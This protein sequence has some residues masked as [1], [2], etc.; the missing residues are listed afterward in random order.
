MKFG[1]LLVF[2][3]LWW[4]I[5]AQ[6]SF[7]LKPATD[8]CSLPPEK[9]AL[10]QVLPCYLQQPDDAFDYR[11][12]QTSEISDKNLWVYSFTLFSQHW[13]PGGTG[14]VDHAVWQ[15]RVTLY[16]PK[17]VRKNT[18]LLYI[19]GGTLYPELKPSEPNRQE[20]DFARIASETNSI[21]INLNDVPNQSLSFS[22]EGALK[23]DDL[24]A[25]TW[26]KFLKNPEQNRHWLLRLPMVKSAVRTMDMVQEFI[27]N[28]N[29]E[30]SGFVVS[31]GSKRG[32][33]AWLT[34]AMDSRVTM[35]APMV[36]DVLN[37]RLSMKHHE[38]AY[39]YWAPAV[40]RSYKDLMP[41]L[42]SEEM[43]KLLSIVDPYSYLKY[44]NI[45]KYIISASAD[46]F[47]LPDSSQFYFDSLPSNKWLRVFPNERHYI[48]RN[49]ALLVT[50]TLLSIYGAHLNG[51]KMPEVNWQLKGDT[52]L[53]SS[54]EAPLSATLWQA[55]N[56]KR[57]DFRATRD[58]PEARKFTAEELTLSCTKVCEFK[59][60]MKMPE[61]GWNAYFI[62]LNYANNNF[63][64]LILTTP[65]FIYPDSYPE[66]A[67]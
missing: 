39:G 2:I 61:S 31:G 26:K 65:V 3:V 30:I 35:V 57:R 25:Y 21:V 60:D 53:V 43:N 42:N 9:Q 50:D 64:D 11:L 54:G 12:E 27:K 52:V 34:S 55:D 1:T 66:F 13:A 24:I 32:W 59:L 4:A 6:A 47:F 17:T 48:V 36:I 49:N 44:L 19:N 33:T 37:L 58:N 62:Q 63:P 67:K 45:P 41:D 51:R 38:A 10:E 23:E 14:S 22:D 40:D 7:Y 15:H 16:V 29:I 56:P 20:I 46:D 5:P 8:Q 28:K 18:A